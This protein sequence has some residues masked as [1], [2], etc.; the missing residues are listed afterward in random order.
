MDNTDIIAQIEEAKALIAII[1][2][3]LAGNTGDPTQ[4]FSVNTGQTQESVQ[5]R[6][7]KDW[8]SMI[9]DLYNLIVVL[10]ARA[11]GSAVTVRPAW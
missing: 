1:W 11:Y 9:E 5:N 8:L 10:E 6:S 3:A 2:A 4:T 7:L